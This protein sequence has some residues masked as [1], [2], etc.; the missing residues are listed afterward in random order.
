MS[1][2]SQ[3]PF[4]FCFSQR[5]REQKEAQEAAQAQKQHQQELESERAAKEAENRRLADEAVS[6]LGLEFGLWKRE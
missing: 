5:A 3:S 2:F 6:L 4:S 1:Q